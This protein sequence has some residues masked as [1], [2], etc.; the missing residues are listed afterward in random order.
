MRVSNVKVNGED[1]DLKR[2]YNV[3]LSEFL[4]TGGDGYTMFAK[5]EVFNDSLMTDT[6]ALAY[7]IKNELNGTIPAK[8]KDSQEIINIANVSVSNT[9]PS[10]TVP[11]TAIPNSTQFQ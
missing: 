8:Y 7:Y 5:Y 4:G 2:M 11:I 1:L 6:D 3:N 10:S 9:V